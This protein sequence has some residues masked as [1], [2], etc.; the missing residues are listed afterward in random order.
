MVVYVL[1]AVKYHLLPEEILHQ[2]ELC[3]CFLV[4]SPDDPPAPRRIEILC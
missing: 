1:D 3:S 4:D 2:L